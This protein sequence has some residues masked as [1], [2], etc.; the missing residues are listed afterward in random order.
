M[1]AGG[2]NKWAEGSGDNCSKGYATATAGEHNENRDHERQLSFGPSYLKSMIRRSLV[3]PCIPTPSPRLRPSCILPRSLFSSAQLVVASAPFQAT[4]DTNAAETS[5]KSLKSTAMS[6]NSAGVVRDSEG[7]ARRSSRGSI[8]VD[9]ADVQLLRSCLDNGDGRM[10]APVSDGGNLRCD[11]QKQ[12]KNAWVDLCSGRVAGVPE[13]QVPNYNLPHQDPLPVLSSI[14][15]TIFVIA[16][17]AGSGK[18]R[19]VRSVF[20]LHGDGKCGGGSAGDSDSGQQEAEVGSSSALPC[21][22]LTGR[23]R[24][25]LGPDSS[26]T[27]LPAHPQELVPY[28]ALQS[29]VEDW[30]DHI[31]RS[32]P[33]TVQYWRTILHDSLNFA[34]RVDDGRGFDGARALLSVIPGLASILMDDDRACE[35]TSTTARVPHGALLDHS[36]DRFSSLFRTLLQTILF[37]S[38]FGQQLPVVL[39]LDDAH[40]LDRPSL[41]LLDSV[42]SA[43]GEGSQPARSSKGTLAVVMTLRNDDP[44]LLESSECWRMLREWSSPEP[45]LPSLLRGLESSHV[46]VRWCNLP[47]M[48]AS[49][50]DRW[51]SYSLKMDA[52]DHLS[53]FSSLL[54]SFCG[55]S[56]GRLV[57]ACCY[58]LETGL[59]YF[60][61]TSSL[62]SWHVEDVEEALSFDL[63]KKKNSE[64]EE[65]RILIKR[66]RLLPSRVAYVLQVASCLGPW[67]NET[68]LESIVSVPVGQSLQ[69]AV[70]RGYLRDVGQLGETK[71]QGYCVFTSDRAHRACYQLILSEERERFHLNV[72]RAL[73]VSLQDELAIETHLFIILS[74]LI[75]SLGVLQ[76]EG[77]ESKVAVASLCLHGGTRAAMSSNFHVASA[78]LGA[79]IRLV[80]DQGWTAN[81]DLTLV[82]HNAAAEMAM[83]TSDHVALNKHI[84]QVLRMARSDSDKLAVRAT[85]IHSLCL[86]GKYQEALEAG[87]STLRDLGES[88]PSSVTPSRLMFLFQRVTRALQSKS[89]EQI[90]RIPDMDDKKRLASMTVYHLLGTALVNVRP[91]LTPYVAL[92]MISL[93]IKHGLSPFSSF[94]F[95]MVGT[96]CQT[97]YGDIDSGLRYGQ[98]GLRVYQRFGRKEFMPRVYGL[99]FGLTHVWKRPIQE[100]LGPLRQGFEG[101][102]HTGDIE[103]ALICGRIYCMTSVEAGSSLH[104]ALR[105]FQRLESVIRSSQHIGMLPGIQSEIQALFD[106]MGYSNDPLSTKRDVIDIDATLSEARRIGQHMLVHA[107]TMT[108]MKVCYIFNDYEQAA[109]H[110]ETSFK[111][112]PPVFSHCTALMT[113]GLVALANAKASRAL[114]RFRHLR[115]ARK[116]ILKLRRLSLQCP[117]N[118]LDKLSL[119]QAEWL[120]VR[121]GR[122]AE[123]Y[124]RYLCALAAA[125]RA[126]FPFM[127]GLISERTARHLRDLESA[128]SVGDPS[129]VVLPA[130]SASLEFFK[131]AARSFEGIGAAAKARQL[132]GEITRSYTAAS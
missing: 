60:D 49:Q 68:L 89:N 119:V 7:Q 22:F 132:R 101:G 80:G 28:A 69:T 31:Y 124:E 40:Y 105:D 83:C 15:T 2:A 32:G 48:D 46:T 35:P 75:L 63:T 21:F 74:Q 61:R 82:L 87:I 6:H 131:Q 90:L 91:E 71:T 67:V 5:T 53:R 123:A 45:S 38:C 1:G 86:Y 65:I 8:V 41:E 78:Y 107:I 118:V 73:W 79:G 130:S 76:L 116:V 27:S 47:P 16:G 96:L 11:V 115:T 14:A 36:E 50:V 3:Q 56:P 77:P 122:D 17:A 126:K 85:Q 99:Y 81:Y 72:G 26:L 125:E 24:P 55:G 106:L 44:I 100:A 51:L 64:D 33:E 127:V 98:L 94:A 112:V 34:A 114:P 108:R 52:I 13:R 37:H 109:A 58:L 18:T 42:I 113:V 97:L 111:R 54:Y 66:L 12:L 70:A 57:E 88:L 104:L 62:W 128:Y 4:S 93:T 19:L 110:M 9:D 59:L 39:F 129:R 29:A 103:G 25:N 30:C 117:E 102:L 92:K 23:S 43:I 10:R 120:S 121:G 84:D 95:A 20:Q